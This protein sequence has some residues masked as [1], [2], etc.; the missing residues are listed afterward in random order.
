ME[1]KELCELR[2]IIEAQK[3]EI[4]ALKKANVLWGKKWFATGDSYTEGDYSHAPYDDWR[5]EGNKRKTYP[6]FIA[7]RNNMT[8]INDGKCGSILPLSKEHLA[9]P[10]NVPVTER[11][12]FTVGRY[13]EIPED[14]D[15]ITLMFGAN[16]ARHDE[17][18]TIDDKENTTF[19]GAWNFILSYLLEKFPFAK[20]GIIV[21]FGSQREYREATRE[22]ARKWAIPMLDLMGD[23]RVPMIF[24]RERELTACPEAVKLRKDAFVV[25]PENGHPG[26][27]A[28]EYLSTTVENFL[29]SL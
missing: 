14:V 17:L 5:L 27:R 13:L 11:R 4:E 1:E 10:E 18:G 15:Y 2:E 22:I 16:D 6:Y 24:G 19:Y 28:H 21:T 12:P 9:D 7:Q 26:L 23:E 29:R 8:V 25:S 20:I 3:K